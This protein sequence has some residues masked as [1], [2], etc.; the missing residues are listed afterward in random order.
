MV[1]KKKLPQCY[2]DNE[3][4]GQAVWSVHHYCLRHLTGGLRRVWRRRERVR[5]SVGKTEA[6]GGV[7]EEGKRR[8][9]DE[10][11]GVWEATREDG[12]SHG[13]A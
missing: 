11:G 2:T 8:G 13:E 3:M 12:G 1:K 9:R 7:G 5:E 6:W 4:V 10:G